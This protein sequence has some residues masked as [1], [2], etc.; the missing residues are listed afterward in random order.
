MAIRPVKQT[1]LFVQG[2]TQPQFTLHETIKSTEKNC[3]TVSE[4]T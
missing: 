3:K 1:Q 2:L 4:S